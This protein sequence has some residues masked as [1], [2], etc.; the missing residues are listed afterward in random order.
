M[1]RIEIGYDVVG[2]YYHSI[3]T[4]DYLCDE[5]TPW[6]EMTEEEKENFVREVAIDVSWEAERDIDE[7]SLGSLCSWEDENGKIHDIS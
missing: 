4:D 1:A 5:D 3:D 7:Y 6:E 2:T